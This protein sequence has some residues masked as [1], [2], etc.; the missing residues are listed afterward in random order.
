MRPFQ[1]VTQRDIVYYAHFCKLDYFAVECPYAAVAFR[2]HP[3]ALIKELESVHPTAVL[4]IVRSGEMFVVPQQPRP[5][6]KQATSPQ[7]TATTTTT[8]TTTTTKQF[9]PAVEGVQPCE[10]C[11]RMTSQKRCQACTLILKLQSM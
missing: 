8:T 9:Q 2:S 3:R 10:R 11:G 4:D 6:L 1:Y 7:T 5:Q